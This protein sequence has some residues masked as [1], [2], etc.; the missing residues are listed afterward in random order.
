MNTEVRRDSLAELIIF[1]LSLLG[2]TESHTNEGREGVGR[3][4]V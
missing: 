1:C 2:R 3:G 4:L